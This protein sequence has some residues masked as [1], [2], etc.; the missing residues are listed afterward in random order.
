[1]AT[2]KARASVHVPALRVVSAGD[3]VTVVMHPWQA[4]HIHDWLR[5]L[6]HIEALD[7]HTIVPGHGPVAGTEALQPL[8]DYLAA[9][10]DPA[11]EAPAGF[12]GWGQP[13][14]WARNVAALAER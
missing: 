13:E 1:M 6:A 12:A 5:F 11:P 9:L 3:L 4:T 7:P 10:L 2:R 8:R 14:M